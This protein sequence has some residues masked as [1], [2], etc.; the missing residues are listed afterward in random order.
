MKRITQKNAP[1]RGDPLNRPPHNRN[2]LVILRV[3]YELACWRTRNVARAKPQCGGGDFVDGI[4]PRP[5]RRG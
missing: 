5:T 4:G 2:A 1:R 3:G